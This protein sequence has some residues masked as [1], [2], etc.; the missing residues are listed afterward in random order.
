MLKDII[1]AARDVFQTSANTPQI[2][3][4]K[5]LV[6]DASELE[7]SQIP[8]LSVKDWVMIHGLDFPLA[9]FGFKESSEAQEWVNPKV[10]D[11]R[12][13]PAY[14]ETFKMPRNEFHRKQPSC[15]NE[16]EV[17]GSFN[18]ILAATLSAVKDLQQTTGTQCLR[19]AVEERLS[20][21]PV[22]TS[23]G[24]RIVQGILDYSLWYGK[25]Q[26]ME[27]NL[28]VC[29]TKW[30]AGELDLLQVLGYMGKCLF[31]LLNL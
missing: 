8:V 25:F 9:T 22:M 27:C 20:Y 21:G 24:E 31:F 26:D 13:K 11:I 30:A 12:L 2:A 28:I 23:V 6:D 15:G 1:H 4:L 29:E 10:A 16:A 5:A 19:I 3:K 7:D 18:S 17:W 14:L